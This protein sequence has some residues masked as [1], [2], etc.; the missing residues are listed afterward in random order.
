MSV[1]LT[2]AERK[3]SRRPTVGVTTGTS[4][5]QRGV[6]SGWQT[7]QEQSAVFGDCAAGRVHDCLE[8]GGFV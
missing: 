8:E 5:V 6:P 4:K 3:P 2:A 7:N 1:A